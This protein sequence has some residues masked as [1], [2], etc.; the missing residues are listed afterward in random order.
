MKTDPRRGTDLFATA[1]VAA[2]TLLPF[3]LVWADE[4]PNEA[5]H[6]LEI[7]WG[8][9]GERNVGGGGSLYGMALSGEVTAV[10][11]WLEVELGAAALGPSGRRERSVE[12]LFKKP[13][14]L[15]ESFEV[16]IGVGPFISRNSGASAPASAH[17][18]E[19]ALDFMFWTS[20]DLGWFLEP[21]WSRTART[22]ERTIGV[23]L[24]V[25][26]GL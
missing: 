6:A 1:L 23:T 11:D 15:S 24:G 21:S 13:F 22:G 18:V 2:L 26:F 9:A 25:V 10:E 14:R 20:R 8:V 4:G 17:G 19:A 5:E 3:T 7:E 12:L 16:M